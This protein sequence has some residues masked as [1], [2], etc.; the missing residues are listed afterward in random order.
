MYLRFILIYCSFFA[1]I[2]RTASAQAFLES[3]PVGTSRDGVLI[4]YGNAGMNNSRIPY[5]RISGSPFWNNEYKT[6]T[7]VDPENKLYG[8]MPVR[9][10]LYTNEIY[11]KT[12]KG[13]ERVASEGRV[14]K[15]FF[16]PNDTS[17]AITT[18]FENELASIKTTN[19]NAQG[20][21]YVQVL[22]QGDFQLLKH[23]KKIFVTAD[24]LFGTMK[25]YYFSEQVH[26]YMNN[27]YGQAYRLKKLNKE[28]VTQEL[29]LDKEEEEWIRQ[30][31]L[32]MR[33]EDEILLFL[34]YLN[35]KRR[36]KG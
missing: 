4:V 6:A 33:K 14:R 21:A 29:N 19:P 28:A 35:E 20:T 2:G 26:Y 25:R 11:F 18:V 10:N 7:L 16:H 36:Q 9:L 3:Q 22:N 24:S 8:K 17:A 30:Q 5:D 13:E 32:S 12:P 23:I 27:K 34:T 1:G 15:I 31:G